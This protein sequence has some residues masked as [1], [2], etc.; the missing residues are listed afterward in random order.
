MR[1]AVSD[2]RLTILS[3]G[4][5]LARVGKDAVGGAEQILSYLDEAIVGAGHRSVVV[6]AESSSV[7]GV[8]VPVPTPDGSLDDSARTSV[9]A[10]TQRAIRHA[11]ERYPVD[12]IHLHGVDF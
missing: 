9:Q 7:R 1:G 12:L 3:V 10:A 11:L 4:Y 2:S 6:A 8:L 5:P